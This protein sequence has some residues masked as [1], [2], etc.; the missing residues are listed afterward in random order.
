MNLYQQVFAI[1]LLS[2]SAL[3]AGCFSPL[4]SRPTAEPLVQTPNTQVIAPKNGFGV[5]P[6]IPS[7]NG[8][9]TI[10]FAK[11]IPELPTSITVIHQPSGNPNE[12]ELRNLAAAIHIPGGAIGNRTFGKET[13][14]EWTD[15]QL[16]HWTYRASQQLLEFHFESAPN[17]PFTV[18]ELPT[19]DTIIQV[20]NSFLNGRGILLR[21]Y[22]DGL[23]EPDWNL[24]WVKGRAQQRCMNTDTLFAIREIASAVSLVS[25]TPPGLPLAQTTT[26]TRTEFPA[27]VIVRYHAMV[28]GLDVVK[29]TG[30]YVQGIE[31]IIDT[32]RNT[33]VSGNITLTRDPER[34]DYAALKTQEVTAALQKG[35][36][37]GT[38]GNIT[39]SSYSI[40]LLKNGE[41]LIPSLKAMGTRKTSA[42]D[43][44]AVQLVVP[45]L[46]R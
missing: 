36:L 42:G 15:D 13:F 24:W 8:N 39:L 25:G 6:T 30:E 35:G 17:T 43:T 38:S 20:A 16:A 12:T 34:S 1:T 41:Y 22:R 19:N 7:T 40:V 10:T 46:A 32:S 11:P 18:Y 5:L 26:C 45:L 33:V 29:P 21:N 28:D 9:P 4:Q 3:G 23:V 14:L 2:C 27:R 37:A 44:E 31:L